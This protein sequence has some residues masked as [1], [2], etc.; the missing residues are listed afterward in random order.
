MRMCQLVEVRRDG[1]GGFA[2]RFGKRGE[3]CSREALE[4]V[5]VAIKA[6]IGRRVGCEV[7]NSIEDSIGILS[8]LGRVCET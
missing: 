7:C 4:A 1:E 8:Q 2:A 5:A 6:P 3:P